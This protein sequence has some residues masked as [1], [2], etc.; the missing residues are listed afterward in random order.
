MGGCCVS[1]LVSPRAL[2]NEWPFIII[3]S[4]V[5]VRRRL[6]VSFVML[7]SCF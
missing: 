5:V 4:T 7:L 1:L 2:R 6:P 3:S